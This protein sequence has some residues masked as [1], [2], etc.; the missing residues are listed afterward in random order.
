[1]N[2]L[3]LWLYFTTAALLA[4]HSGSSL[5]QIPSPPNEAPLIGSW[6]VSVAG[7]QATRTLIISEVAPTETAALL[8]VRYGMSSGKQSA[9]EAKMIRLGVVRQ[10]HLVTQAATIIEATEQPDGTFTGTFTLK[11]GAVKDVLISRLREQDLRTPS[12]ADLENFKPYE[13]VGDWIFLNSSSGTKY[14]GDVAVKIDKLDKLGTMRG[15]ISYDGRQLNDACGTRGVLSD[16]PVAAEIIK[17]RD[18]YRISFMTKC[19]RGQSPR[20]FSW[21]LVCDTASCTQPTVLP[22]GR[23]VLTL[24]EKR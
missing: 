22:H 7:E 11:N 10:L 12:Q 6:L 1:M 17:S 3:R 16:E 14:G 8:A 19:L 21:T 15:M 5:A 18:E 23:G 13:L 2:L 9:I 20:L 24:T 4:W